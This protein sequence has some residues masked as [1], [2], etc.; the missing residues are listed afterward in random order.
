LVTF[1]IVLNAVIACADL[2]IKYARRKKKQ[3]YT[4]LNLEPYVLD[5]QNAKKT[6]VMDH[7][8]KQSLT[9]W[10]ACGLLGTLS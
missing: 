1:T 6:N 4:G 3:G 2:Q 9:G 10:L 7:F 5:C 8:T